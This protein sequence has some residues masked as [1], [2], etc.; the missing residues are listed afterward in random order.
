M[1]KPITKIIIHWHENDDD[2]NFIEDDTIFTSFREVNEAIRRVYD[3]DWRKLRSG[4]LY[5]KYK[6]SL[7]ANDD[8]GE[9]IVLHTGRMY[10]SLEEDNPFIT[11]NVLGLHMVNLWKNSDQHKHNLLIYSF[12]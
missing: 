1:R 11:D 12:Y 7:I 8:N 4:G 6:F 2:S 10:I 5:H 3:N 9:E